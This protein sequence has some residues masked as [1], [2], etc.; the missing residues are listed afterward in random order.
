MGLEEDY[1]KLVDEQNSVKE[2]LKKELPE[3]RR[4][5]NWIIEN[6]V[7]NRLYIEKTLDKLLK[8]IVFGAGNFEYY[9]LNN[10][11]F[12]VFPQ[13]SKKYKELYEKVSGKKYQ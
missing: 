8:I 9:K 1:Q 4:T 2:A 10:F 5:I 6:E 3:I 7:H 12:T 13:S 11:Y